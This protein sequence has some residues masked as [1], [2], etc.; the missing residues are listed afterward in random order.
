MSIRWREAIQLVR[1]R[2]PGA[3][4]RGVGSSDPA[5]VKRVAIGRVSERVADQPSAVV[6]VYHGRVSLAAELEPLH[7]F[8]AA[9]YNR[10]IESGGLDED[11]RVELL[12]GLLVAVSPKSPAHENAVAFLLRWLMTA[13]LD[14]GRY[15]LRVASPLSLADD[16]Q[17]EPDLAV[18]AL[19]SPRPFHPA[20]AALVIE[21]AVSSLPRDLQVKPGRY[22]AAGV[23]EYWVVDLTGRRVVVH[24]EPATSG[25]ARTVTVGDGVQLAPVSVAL[26]PLDV[27]GLFAAVA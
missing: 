13:A 14:L 5:A 23:S 20:S 27:A 21:V 4:S 25:Y 11:A 22:A 12:D 16:S 7:R 3:P 10:L 1:A 24:T 2:A 19:D 26:T 18:I 17:P 8:T 6:Y 15:E 9:E